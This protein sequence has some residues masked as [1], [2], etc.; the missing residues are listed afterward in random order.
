YF[1][2]GK[3]PAEFMPGGLDG[4]RHAAYRQHRRDVYRQFQDATL[5]KLT[6][7]LDDARYADPAAEYLLPALAR[8]LGLDLDI[9]H[10][11]G[12]A[13]H[14]RFGT[15]GGPAY[16]LFREDVDNGHYHVAID[17]AGQPITTHSSLSHTT[18]YSG[19]PLRGG[20]PNVIRNERVVRETLEYHDP[21]EQGRVRDD[22]V[23]VFDTNAAGASFGFH[24]L[25]TH[26][27]QTP[28]Q[29]AALSAYVEQSFVN[30]LLRLPEIE[31]DE[32]IDRIAK[33]A[34][35]DTLITAAGTA[36]DLLDIDALQGRRDN[37]RAI[38]DRTDAQSQEL[39]A[40]DTFLNHPYPDS[41]WE[42]VRGD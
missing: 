27:R 36:G 38:A 32:A 12:K 20:A 18:S 1:M 35:L 4:E 9:Q 21:G 11:D 13:D 6:E 37:L 7:F 34:K 5:G 15:A 26:D 42:T 33:Q 23:R 29:R 41:Y 16:V 17:S 25:R 40:L 24:Q 14:L 3:P 2:P 28:E 10:P 31:R 30:D 39:S 19:N 22:G 8:S